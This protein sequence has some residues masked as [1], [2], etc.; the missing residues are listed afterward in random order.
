MS[1]LAWG[2]GGAALLGVAVI[3]ITVLAGARAT[4]SEVAAGDDVQVVRVTRR[5]IGSVVKATGVIKPRVGAEV[6]VGSRISGVVK[7]LHVRIGDAV[8]KGQ[9]LAELDERDLV[10][11]RD[12]AAATLRQGEVTLGFAKLDL[13]R[14]R[15]L[16]TKG[17]L[18]A[19][20]LEPAERAFAVG[21]QQVNGARASLAY[22]N[23][24]LEYARIVA[25]ISGLVSSVSTQEGETVAASFAAPTFLTLLDPTRM[26]VWAYVD[27]TDIGRIRIGQKARFTVDTY[28]DHP[29]DGQVTAIY[30]KAE[31]RDNVVNYV[32]VVTFTPPRDRTLRPEMTTAV[33]ISLDVHQGALVVP[34]RAL[35]TDA[36][37][38]YVLISNRNATE[39]R[40]V[41]TGIRDDTYVEITTGLKAGDQVVVGEAASS[42]EPR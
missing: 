21:E 27:E 29:F 25:P 26:E 22:A 8:A 35:R 31:I 11:R 13:D 15:A 42:R 24:Q 37:R 10:A 20:E 28:G 32:S 23:A 14:K 3:A 1:K 16:S 30:P 4:P 34:I 19:S 5:D 7:R 36:G 40:D 39:R 6:R 33:R 2:A 18:A 9:L 17:S 12:E 41:T 38:R